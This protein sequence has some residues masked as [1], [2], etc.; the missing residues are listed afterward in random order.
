VAG[1]LIFLGRRAAV[2]LGLLI[3]LLAA[4]ADRSCGWWLAGE[5]KHGGGSGW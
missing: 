5:V 3:S 2:I 1:E 4:I